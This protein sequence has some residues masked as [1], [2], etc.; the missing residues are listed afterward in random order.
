MIIK[1][2]LRL[3]FVLLIGLGAVFLLPRTAQ[4][5]P[6]GI[7]M[8]LPIWVGGW[9]GE[10][11]AVTERE[12]EVLAKDT[13]FARKIYSSPAGDKLFV[14]IVMSG[15]DMTTSIHRPERC[16]PAQGWGLQA[17]S[18]VTIPLKSAPLAITRL[19][20]AREFTGNDGQKVTVHN[21][22]YY[23]FIGYGEI[24]ASHI[25]RTVIDLRDRIL[26]GYNQKWAYITVAGTVTQNLT[27]PGRS[28]KETDAIIHQF[29]EE[30]VPQ[31]KAPDGSPVMV[32]N[33]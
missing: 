13:Q 25:T 26:R 10:D 9:I 24:T 3:A 4:T 32:A 27:P 2:L 31:L 18:K 1:R 28:E 20:A 16:L 8:S 17:T 23:W 33:R 30:L 19:A 29:V 21:V 5:S 22:T 7:A 15:D 11:V 14:S 6:A 12:R